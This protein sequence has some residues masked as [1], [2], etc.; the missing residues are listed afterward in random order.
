ML[1]WLNV[2]LSGYFVGWIDDVAVYLTAF[3][4]S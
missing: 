4:L 2:F 1:S 3:I